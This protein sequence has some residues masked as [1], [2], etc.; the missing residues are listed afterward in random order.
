MPMEQIHPDGLFEAVVADRGTPCAYRLRWT[1]AAGA[2][3]EVE[4]PYRFPSMLSDFDLYLL[5][6]G[7]HYRAYGNL[8]AQQISWGTLVTL[9]VVAFRG[10]GMAP[11]V[12]VVMGLRGHGSQE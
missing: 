12:F 8:F 10:A 5:G 9:A 6:E 7:T 11:P 4:D 1:G 3:T 2:E